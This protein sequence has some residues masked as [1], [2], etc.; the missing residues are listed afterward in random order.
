MTFWLNEKN[1]TCPGCGAAITNAA[2]RCFRCNKGHSAKMMLK[3]RSARPAP[4]GTVFETVE[5]FLNRGGEIN[6]IATATI[7][8]VGG[9]PVFHKTHIRR[10]GRAA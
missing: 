6:R 3:G 4:D 9:V 10:S 5:Q 1:K 7:P 2:E 8:Y